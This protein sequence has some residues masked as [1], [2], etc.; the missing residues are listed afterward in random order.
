MRPASAANSGTKPSESVKAFLCAV[1][2]KLLSMVTNDTTTKPTALDTQ[3][4]RTMRGLST[5]DLVV[6]ATFFT[7]F[8]MVIPRTMGRKM[9]EMKNCHNISL[10]I[11]WIL[12]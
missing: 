6:I 12:K 10:E 4:Q 2:R 5:S 1:E 3:V 11:H 9:V 8:T 7:I